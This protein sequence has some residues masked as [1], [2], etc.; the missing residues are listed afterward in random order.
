MMHINDLLSWLSIIGVKIKASLI[1][2]FLSFITNAIKLESLLRQEST[3]KRKVINKSEKSMHKKN[4]WY[5]WN[6]N[7]I[8]RKIQ[9]LN[10]HMH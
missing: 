1:S 10:L 5:V 8:E 9:W 2:F 4:L 7:Y 6:I 3:S